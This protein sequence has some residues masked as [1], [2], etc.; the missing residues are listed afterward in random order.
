[1]D[2]Q[3]GRRTGR[4]AGGGLGPGRVGEGDAIQ[5]GPGR[6]HP[7]LC[8]EAVVVPLA[9]VLVLDVGDTLV[10]PLGLVV[11]IGHALQA[12]PLAV[13]EMG[14]TAS[15]QVDAPRGWSL[16]TLACFRDPSPGPP[17]PNL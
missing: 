1:M 8:D 6:E 3:T 4:R 17:L 14:G 13:E 2:G 16:R 9:A 5:L 10:R 15:A 7:L 11:V 12:G